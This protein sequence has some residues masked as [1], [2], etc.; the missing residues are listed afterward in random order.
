MTFLESAKKVYSDVTLLLN[1]IQLLALDKDPNEPFSECM[2]ILWLGLKRIILL[3]K[4]SYFL[5]NFSYTVLC[6]S[7]VQGKGQ[8]G[9]GSQLKCLIQFIYNEQLDHI[10]SISILI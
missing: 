4:F 5:A 9:S 3:Q 7:V 10:P 1:K 8:L 2:S 6:R